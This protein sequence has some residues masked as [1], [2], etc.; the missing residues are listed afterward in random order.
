MLDLD[1]HITA[2]VLKAVVNH[3]FA[4]P[5]DW[6]DGLDELSTFSESE[7]ELLAAS[8]PDHVWSRKRPIGVTKKQARE[9]RKLFERFR[10]E[11]NGAI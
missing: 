1:D 10:G 2:H 6:A 11:C 3:G 8:E 9:D 7:I 5:S 4:D